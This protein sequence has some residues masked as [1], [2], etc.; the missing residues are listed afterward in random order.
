MPFK[1]ARTVTGPHGTWELYVS[2]YVGVLD[3]ERMRARE[4]ER[5]REGF[6]KEDEAEEFAA[7]GPRGLL[8][9]LFGRSRSSA[10]KI[11]AINWGPPDE[12]LVWTT[13]TEE[14]ERVLDALVEGFRQ[15]EVVQPP[16]A[17]YTGEVDA[18]A[19]DDGM[20]PP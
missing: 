3:D 9:D 11:E 18:Y 16:G 1:P 13:T 20:I 15:G 14:V 12:K 19:P 8:R 6:V 10:V 4:L 2:K 17:V 5:R 7:H